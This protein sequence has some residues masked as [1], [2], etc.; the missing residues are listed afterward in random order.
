MCDYKGN[1]AFDT[2]CFFMMMY[3]TSNTTQKTARAKMKI[4]YI[5]NA[6]WLVI[7]SGMIVLGSLSPS[8]SP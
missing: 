3:R 1:I 4:P 7:I 2:H 5:K 6:S 8:G